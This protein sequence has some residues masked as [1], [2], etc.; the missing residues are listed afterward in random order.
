MVQNSY[1]FDDR[2]WDQLRKSDEK[3]R[4]LRVYLMGNLIILQCEY[5]V[6]L[7]SGLCWTPWNTEVISLQTVYIIPFNVAVLRKGKQMIN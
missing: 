3:K 5:Y 6:I 4:A 2:K 1:A 7:N